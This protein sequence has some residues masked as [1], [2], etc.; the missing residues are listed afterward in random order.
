MNW[1]KALSIVS[2]LVDIWKKVR[3]EKVSEADKMPSGNAVDVDILP[4]VWDVTEA[5]EE[6]EFAKRL[7]QQIERD[8]GMRLKP[9]RDSVGKLTI[10]VGRNL[11]DRGISEGEAYAMLVNDIALAESEV[12]GLAFYDKL[13]NPRKAVVINMVFNLG[14]V[15][16]LG[17]R[18]M[19][20]ALNAGDYEKAAAEM[21]DS[22]WAQQVGAR[23]V[24]L[25]EQMKFG[26]WV[27]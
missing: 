10:G 4:S 15:R 23:A 11:D 1:L 26:E 6:I 21:L 22:K 3:P 9:Y 8:E 17:F 19:I 14:I 20:A 27:N 13:N 5:R 2:L 24:R 12:S 16:F 7:E 18:N 25:A